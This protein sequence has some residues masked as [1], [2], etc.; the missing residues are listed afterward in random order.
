[1]INTILVEDEELLR[2]GLCTCVEWEYLGYKILAA[3]ENGE[4]CL[5][6]LNMIPRE[7]FPSLIISDIRM[8]RIDGIEMLERIRTKWKTM[9]FIIIT[10][11]DEFEYAKKAVTL[12][13][14]EYILKPVNLEQLNNTL[15]SLERKIKNENEQT[16]KLIQL[17]NME[18]E[19]MH[20][21][22]QKI[23]ASLLL[24]NGKLEDL[25]FKIE[26]LSEPALDLF[27][28]VAI[29]E[30]E[31]IVSQSMNNDYIELLE[32]DR[33]FEGR[34][35]KILS[36]LKEKNN[37]GAMDESGFEILRSG[38]G[39]RLICIREKNPQSIHFL[40]QQLMDVINKNSENE[41][42]A[43]QITFGTVQKG[44]D[45]MIM[46][47]KNA[48][49]KNEEQM[50]Q[51]NIKFFLQNMEQDDLQFDSSKILY[52]IRNGTEEGLHSC[53]KEWELYLKERNLNSYIQTVYEV[54]KLYSQIIHLPELEGISA[55]NILGDTRERY[56]AIVEKKKTSFMIDEIEKIALEVQK[57][58]NNDPG[59]RLQTVV[60]QTKEFIENN[61]MRNITI[62]NAADHV[63]LS[64]SYL[65]SVL[66]KE[67]G[68]T[69]IELLTN[70]RI[71]HA[72]HLLKTTELVNSEVAFKSGYINST[73]FSTVFKSIT[74]KSPSV[75]RKENSEE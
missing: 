45:G 61:Y 72:K 23:Y 6:Y 13:V 2:N 66:K 64:S 5:Q 22:R 11:Y 57:Y 1:M 14:Y 12:G 69:Y 73:Y 63:F 4:E 46:S 56:I 75:W 55:K 52:Q 9:H 47:Y 59:S 24:E 58:I 62:K 41:I 35:Q 3:L 33:V 7:N 67:T 20:L 28:S 49:E 17:Q 15:Q 65:S 36:K 42:S 29:I 18:H 40:S 32:M 21:L 30:T 71:N 10:G 25:F 43:L 54:S 34:I 27:Y 53:I 19:N 60:N 48:Y 44:L 37:S 68:Q 26:K 8:P 16:N 74:G 50:T 51:N 38:N 39:E 70:C 31:N